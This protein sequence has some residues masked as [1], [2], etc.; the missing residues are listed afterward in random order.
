M[1]SLESKRLREELIQLRLARHELKRV[2]LDEKEQPAPD[3]Q[4]ES[5][6]VPLELVTVSQSSEESISLSELCDRFVE[7]K[8]EQGLRQK[9]I[10]DT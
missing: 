4:V 3:T 9:V 1:D 5:Q 8:V 6:S 7:V 10:D 2:I